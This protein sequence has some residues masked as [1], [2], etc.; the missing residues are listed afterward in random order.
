LAYVKYRVVGR[1][2][3]M[4]HDFFIVS[5]GFD[6]ALGD[7]MGEMRVT[8]T[9]YA[10]IIKKVVELQRGRDVVLVLEGGYAAEETSSSIAAC[11]RA[12]LGQEIPACHGQATAAG[13]VDILS[14]LSV[15]VEHWKGLKESIPAALA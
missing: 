14:T 11:A 3:I 13:L 6:A 12:L 4:L 10:N 2:D 8:P 7:N 15:H 1:R 5:A 9:G